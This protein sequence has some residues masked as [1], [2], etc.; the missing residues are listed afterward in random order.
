[1]SREE[2]SKAIGELLLEAAVEEMG[3]DWCRELLIRIE[4]QELLEQV[5]IVGG[6]VQ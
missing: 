2:A 4:K 5:Q 1:M 3:V 6:L